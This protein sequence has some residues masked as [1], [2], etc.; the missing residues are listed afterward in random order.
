MRRKSAASGGGWLDPWTKM[1]GDYGNGSGL[2]ADDSGRFHC[3]TVKFGSTVVH[4][5]PHYSPLQL[6]H[7]KDCF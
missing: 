7:G 4:Y 3:S 1:N 5:A 6:F 2:S